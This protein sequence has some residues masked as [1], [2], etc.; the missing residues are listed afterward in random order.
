MAV[1][2]PNLGNYR[3][4][5]A[6]ERTSLESVVPLKTPYVIMVDPASVCN[7][8][9]LFCPTGDLKRIKETGR[10]QGLMKP[11]IFEK[12]LDDVTNFPDP[13]KV[14][15]L[16]KEG[17]PLVNPKFTEFVH[18]A[19]RNKN[20]LRVDTTTNGLNLSPSLNQE[21]IDS[22]ID[23]IN[24]SV[25]GMTEE[26]FLR[27]TKKSVN[28]NKF[29][30]NIIDLCNRSGDTE[31]YVKAIRENLSDFERELFIEKFSDYADRIYFEGLQ[32]N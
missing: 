24:I 13:I 29:V 31:I 4:R 20:I 2:L 25:N 6:Y 32:P 30:D 23:Q 12:I 19:K 7:L 15:R 14:L 11:E 17:E 5:T 28:I 10:Y 8:K 9:C 16:Y 21:L 22:G 1:E 27:L 3:K 18:A 26:T